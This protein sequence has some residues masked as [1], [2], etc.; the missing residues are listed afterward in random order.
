MKFPKPFPFPFTGTPTRPV[1][2][3]FFTSTTPAPLSPRHPYFIPR[4]S[5]GSLPIYSDVRNGGTR[6][7]ISVRK[8]EG[9]IKV[10]DPVTYNRSSLIFPSHQR[11]WPMI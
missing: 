4:N 6:Y 8:V 10:S 7:L 11:P 5:R 9:N 1:T 2:P 3:R